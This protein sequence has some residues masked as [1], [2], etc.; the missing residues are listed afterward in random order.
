MQ[1]RTARLAA[2]LILLTAG[3]ALNLVGIAWLRPLG[4]ALLVFTAFLSSL[5]RKVVAGLLLLLFAG[6]AVSS[7][8]ALPALEMLHWHIMHPYSFPLRTPCPMWQWIVVAIIWLAS[9]GWECW[10]WGM[11]RMPPQENRV[12]KIDRLWLWVCLV[13]WIS[14]TGYIVSRGSEQTV[15]AVVVTSQVV[16][17]LLAGGIWMLFFVG[18]SLRIALNLL[19]TERRRQRV[20]ETVICVV[21]LLAGGLVFWLYTIERIRSGTSMVPSRTHEVC[22]K[23]GSRGFSRG[24][25]G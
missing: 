4:F 10:S 18:M 21:V 2:F 11:A 24:N 22:R 16:L 25:R 19:V 17:G 12:A 6:L 5:P 9:L 7:W 15:G 3:M 14:A 20:R 23:T 8:L 13:V 1:S